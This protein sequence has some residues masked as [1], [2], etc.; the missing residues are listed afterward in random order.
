[1]LL[2][3][4]SLCHI[5]TCYVLIIY[6]FSIDK[7]KD[8]WIQEDGSWY[9]YKE[10][11]KQTDWQTIDG[12]DYFFDSTGKMKTGWFND[13]G[14]WYYLSS[15]GVKQKGWLNLGGTWY[16]L[17]EEDGGMQTG[18]QYRWTYILLL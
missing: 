18:L 10:G 15:N 6:T 13:Y 11:V 9:Y 1:M 2:S 7:A 8:G 14:T 3:C 4:K 17:S 5:I 12:K 16:Y